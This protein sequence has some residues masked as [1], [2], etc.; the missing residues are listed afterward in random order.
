MLK[1][2]KLKKF[3][4]DIKGVDKIDLSVNKGEIFGF[5][6]PNGAGKSTTIR[7]IMNL[8]YKDNGEILVDGKVNEK[9][10]Y[11]LKEDIGYLPGEINLYDDLTVKEMINYSASFYKKDC[12]QKT[13]YLVNK[14]NLDLN[15]KT[16]ELSLGNLK[17]LGIVLALMHSPKLIIL[18]EATSGLDPLMQE[19]F[20]EILKEEKEKGNTIF[21]SS[22]I[23]SEIKKICDRVAIIKEGK[24]IEVK[25][26][27]ELVNN[28]YLLITIESS[29]ISKIKN[30]LKENYLYDNKNTIKF[31]YNGNIKNILEKINKY[32]IDKL[33]IEEPSIEEIFMHF[34]E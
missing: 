5:I 11:L 14:L 10:S 27:K 4:G 16:E 20:Y 28:E 30:E 29:E 9:N 33:L 6:G 31:S 34:Y 21:F 22:H 32:K 8:I 26:I 2:S 13:K 18:D 7:C 1:I 24:I 19:T 15:K 12:S 3:Y 25:D 23:L 17:K